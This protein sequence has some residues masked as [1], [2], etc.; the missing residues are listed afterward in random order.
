M[1]NEPRVLLI[2][3][4]HDGADSTA[5]PVVAGN[6]EI[7]VARTMARAIALL[8]EQ[9]FAGVYVPA[10][11][12]AS[13]RWAAVLLQAEEI[14]EAIADGV[15]VV[16]PAD[17]RILWVNQEFKTLIP[18]G[19]EPLGKPFYEALIQPERLG[20]DP[21]PFETA[22][23]TR[24][25]ASAL[26]RI[27]GNRH[28]RLNVTATLDPTGHVQNLVALT[29]DITLEV[30]QEQKMNTIHR[31]GEE[32]AGLA[33]EE[34]AKMPVADRTALLKYDI[35]RH[36]RELLGIDFL[37]IRLLERETG[38][39]VPLL[40][41]GMTVVA[42]RR[43]LFARETGNG[44]TGYVAATGRSY[45][46]PDAADD[47]LY[48]EGADGARSSLTVPLLHNGKIIGTLNVENRKPGAY[49]E[50][51]R[52]FLEIYGRNIASA[53]NTLELLQAEIISTAT[54]SIDAI[55]RELALPLDD[56]LSDA[57]TALDR[58]SGHDEDIVHRLRHL[59]ARAREIRGLIKHA[60]ASV[61]PET[62]AEAPQPPK[63]AN[64]RILV[65]DAEESTR[66]A[67][68]HL[69]GRLGAIVETA[70]DAQEAIAF[71]RQTTYSVAVVDIRLPDL[72]GYHTYKRLREV[73]PGIGVILMTGYGY[74]PTHSI[75]NARREGLNS[76]LYKP[77]R[78]DR[79]TETV[80]QAVRALVPPSANDSRP[81]APAPPPVS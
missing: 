21:C 25:P 75:V 37:E 36:M 9:E 74:D 54:A 3:R 78:V 4:D 34:L 38:R 40:T 6:H 24:R 15:A 1:A 60:G 79:L 46:C 51:D 5:V 2:D 10:S 71:A 28:F 48:L 56:I 76:V 58:Y 42:A 55:S 59:L 70:R 72:D 77:F 68:H 69:L 7:V 32:L 63:L 80:E 67:A 14:L 23:D 16:D 73:Q 33:P 45:L 50:R 12:L 61:L 35:T 43:E 11:S 13:L 19:S 66:K 18:E 39:L 26:L 22:R 44:V 17:F 8:R 20:G 57:T 52:Q 49:D 29:R 62:P 27:G 64:T 47:P 81:T 65:V 30:H 53:L 31:A 41:E